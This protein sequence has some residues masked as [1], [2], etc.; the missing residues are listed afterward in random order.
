MITLTSIQTL[1]SVEEE[2]STLMKN[3]EELYTLWAHAVQL[4][5]KLQ[6]R[7]QSLCK[8]LEQT[9]NLPDDVQALPASVRSLYIEEVQK[10]RRQTDDAQLQQLIQT[11]SSE[12]QEAFCAMT[13]GA[14]PE[15][16]KGVSK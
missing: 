11:L 12:E 14:T 5:R 9:E 10:L 7:Y 4:T 16:I 6:L 13:A 2:R 8:L 15:S 1:R 3:N